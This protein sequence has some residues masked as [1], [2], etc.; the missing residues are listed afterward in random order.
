MK[1][2]YL[3]GLGQNP[4]SWSKVIEQLEAAEHSMCPDL[5]E[6]VQGQDTTYQNLYA[7]FSAMCD[8][9]EEDICLCGLSLGGV[10]ALNYAIEHPEKIKGLV[11]IATQYK[12]PKK[13][14]RVQ[15]AIFRFMPKSMFQQTGF[16]KSDFLKL[17]NTMMELDFSDSIYNVSCP[18]LVIY[19]EKD[20]AN[21]N[22]S[23]ELANMLIDAELQV[24]NGVGHEINIEAP[25]KLEETLRV[26]FGKV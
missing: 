26:F 19:G 13:L 10:L 15:N 4:D 1:Q 2:I 12:M 16:G 21:K 9:I 11:L 5:S 18:T 22:A 23:I 7:A 8:E 6:L 17:C 24:F 14:L 20:R 3:H 25:D